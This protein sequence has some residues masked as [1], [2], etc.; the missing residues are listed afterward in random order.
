M[1]INF[2]LKYNSGFE[3]VDLFP[4]T[5]VKAV[6]NNGVIKQAVVF[7]T[8]PPSNQESQLVPIETTDMYLDAPMY[9]EPLFN[10]PTDYISYQTISQVEVIEGNLK[11]TRLYGTQATEPVRIAIYFGINDVQ[12]IRESVV[13]VTIPAFAGGLEQEVQTAFTRGQQLAPFYVK[14]ESTVSSEIGDYSKISQIR[15]V[16]NKLKIVR[17]NEQSSGQV[18][19][20][21][22]FEESGE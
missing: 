7:V 22:N 9:I 3:Y 8:I 13:R 1:A 5:E 19:I 20:S 21:L 18:K 10:T 11:I 17:L 14:C 2:G 15:I 4:Q 6:E 16:D 12:V